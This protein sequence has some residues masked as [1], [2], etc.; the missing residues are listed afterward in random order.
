MSYT[1]ANKVNTNSKTLYRIG[2]YAALIAVVFFRRYLAAE[3][4]AFNGF[5]IFDVPKEAP[6]TAIGWFTLLQKNKF[7]GL[8]LLD[9]FD[10]VN[11][12]LMGLIFLALYAACSIFFFVFYNLPA[13]WLAMHADPWPEDIQK[14]SYFM[15]GMFGEGTG[16]LCPDRGESRP[17]G[18]GNNPFQA[19]ECV[20]L[21]AQIQVARAVPWAAYL[22]IYDG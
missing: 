7:L 11:Y 10:L 4:M 14:R 2:A 3:L 9:I 6:V 19:Y 12:A 5:G 21:C 18:C 16:R 1:S 13:Q 20:P 8:A 17:R 22:I 15:N